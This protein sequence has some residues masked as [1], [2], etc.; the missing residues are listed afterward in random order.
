MLATPGQGFAGGFHGN[1]GLARHAH[2]AQPA[3]ITFKPI[4]LFHVLPRAN[5]VPSALLL[6]VAAL[7]DGMRWAAVDALAAGAVGEIQ[8]IGPVVGIRPRCGL[9]RYPGHHRSDPHGLSLGGD[10]PVAQAEG[11]QAGRCIAAADIESAVYV[12]PQLFQAQGQ[13]HHLYG[14]AG[15]DLVMAC[16]MQN[17]QRSC[18][19]DR[20]LSRVLAPTVKIAYRTQEVHLKMAAGGAQSANKDGAGTA[21]RGYNC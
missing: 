1:A 10:E 3:S 21:G 12:M 4:G 15:A 9:D 16:H 19:H 7:G 18:A 8:A 5:Q 2:L 11:A 6:V 13:P 20:V 17:F 14:A